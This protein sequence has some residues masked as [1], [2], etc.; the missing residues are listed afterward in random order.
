MAAS[1]VSELLTL[2]RETFYSLPRVSAANCNRAEVQVGLFEILI[3]LN[4]DVV[5]VVMGIH[6]LALYLELQTL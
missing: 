1:R 2:K 4:P 6:A 3:A 5:S